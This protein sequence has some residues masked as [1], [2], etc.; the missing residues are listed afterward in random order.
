MSHELIIFKTQKTKFNYEEITQAISAM[1]QVYDEGRLK[2]SKYTI[3][4]GKYKFD[5][6]YVCF[7]LS[8][9]LLSIS[10]DSLSKPA[11]HFAYSLQQKLNLGLSAIDDNY[12]FL[13]QLNRISSVEQLENIA[14]QGIYI[15]E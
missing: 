4:I 5:N 3:F 9:D 1:T 14:F 13:C 8:H 15:N 6:E 10:T 2:N 11:F 12:S 7:S